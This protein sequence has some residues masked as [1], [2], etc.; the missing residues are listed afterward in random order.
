M[1]KA[2]K[3]YLHVKIFVDKEFYQFEAC[4]GTLIILSDLKRALMRICIEMKFNRKNGESEGPVYLDCLFD[5]GL[6]RI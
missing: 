2:S 5:G 6:I 3:F 1:T 4:S